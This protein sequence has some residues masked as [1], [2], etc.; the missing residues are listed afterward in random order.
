MENQQ[1]EERNP[2]RQGQPLNKRLLR[3]MVN[4][5]NRF[6]K[7][8]NEKENLAKTVRANEEDIE[9]KK[10]K[11]AIAKIRQKEEWKKSMGERE[12]ERDKEWF[13][14]PSKGE[15]T[16]TDPELDAFLK[17]KESRVDEIEEPVDGLPHPPVIKQKKEMK[18]VETEVGVKKEETVFSAAEDR[19]EKRVQREE[20][21]EQGVRGVAMNQIRNRQDENKDEGEEFSH[22][23]A[24][25]GDIEDGGNISSQLRQEI[26]GLGQQE[27]PKSPNIKPI[28]G[29]MK[30]ITDQGETLEETA[31]LVN[32]DQGEKF[33]K[34]MNLARRRV[35]ENIKAE[36]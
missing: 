5:L 35:K 9:Q 4:G 31:N 14:K 23:P 34:R 30:E 3:S 19:Q 32:K 12:Q 25:K 20:Q 1:A 10:T 16:E 26:A 6:F 36:S 33:E 18:N 15:K 28:L 21:D 22:V 24:L 27:S 13:D 7:G 2:E 29:R 11:G 8:T 17:E